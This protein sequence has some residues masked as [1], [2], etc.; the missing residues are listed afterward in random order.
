MRTELGVEL[1]YD[2]EEEVELILLGIDRESGQAWLAELAKKQPKCA[3]ATKRT[4][5]GNVPPGLG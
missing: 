3:P 4:L 2:L 1:E 5:E